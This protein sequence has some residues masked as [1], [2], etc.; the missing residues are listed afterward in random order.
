MKA[1]KEE[2]LQV[3]SGWIENV[4]TRHEIRSTPT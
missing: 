1:R 3:L 4:R 2:S